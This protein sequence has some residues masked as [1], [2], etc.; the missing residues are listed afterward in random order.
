[1]A[2]RNIK[3]TIAYD[4]SGYHGWQLQPDVPTIQQEIS[5]AIQKLC[6]EPV[7]VTGSSRTDAGVHALGQVANIL[8]ES[9]IPTQNFPQAI[10][11]LLPVDIA[12]IEAVEVHENFNAINSAKRKWYRYTVFTGPNRP[13]LDTRNCWHYCGNFNVKAMN[14]AASLLVGKN[15]FKS[16][17]TASDT[18]LNS[19]RTIF[20]CGLERA[21]SFLHFDITGD[22]FLYNMVRNIVGTLMEVGRG[23]WEPDY[24]D[25]ILAAKDRSKAGPLAPAAGLC[26]MKIYFDQS[27]KDK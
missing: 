27:N 6:G 24:I 10:T 25:H 20:S 21:D 15:D 11:N 1:M 14:A 7:R 12:V 19:V 2:L 22:G 3:L 5:D 23:R 18:R 26:L 9:P 13:V 8:V 16:F 17:A 4:G